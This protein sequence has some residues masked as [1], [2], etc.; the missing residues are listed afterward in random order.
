[1]NHNELGDISDF[2][3]VI[4]SVSGNVALLELARLIV[5]ITEKKINFADLPFFKLL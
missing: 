2:F 4:L 1:M 3:G 5:E